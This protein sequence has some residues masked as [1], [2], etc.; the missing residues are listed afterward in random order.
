M[1]FING[2]A[3]EQ[4]TLFPP[5]LDEL[6]PDDHVCRVID[7]FVDQLEMGTLGFERAEPA[8]TG[9]PGYDPRDLLKLLLYG[10]LQQ[11]R[12]SRRLEAECRRN[13]ELMWLLGRLRPDHKSIAEFRRMH[14]DAITDTAA[15][16]VGFA[17]SE[18]LI[19]GEWVAIDGS[20]FRAVS[21]S[22]RLGERQ[23]ALRYLEQMEE[24]DA[25]DTELTINAAAVAA[26]LQKLKQDPEP[27][28][29]FMRTS[30]GNLPAYNVQAAVDAEH[31]LIVAHQVTTQAN[32]R[33]SLLPMAQAAQAAATE[34][35]QLLHVVADGG[36]SNGAQAEACEA[37]GILPHVPVQRSLNSQG[38]GAAFDR[39]LFVYNPESDTFTCPAGHSLTRKKRKARAI[40]YAAQPATCG[41][42]ALKSQCTSSTR[43]TIKRHRHE[44]A[45]QRMQQRATAEAMRLRRCRAEFPFAILKYHIFGSARFLLRGLRGAQ[46]EISLGVIA[47]NLKRM[48]KV[49]ASTRLTAALSAA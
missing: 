44:E 30:Q 6:V 9:R 2:E 49:V 47:Y 20:K 25:E 26:A 40:I 46:T 32:D 5:T 27:E 22:N 11:I 4:Q 38:G 35:G 16:L 24:A 29:R 48:C 41:S 18:G 3:R 37:R 15:E 28:A 8:D 33:R 21:S 42:C 45:L 7:A 10:Y 34:P 36:Y 19:R 14:R 23:R 39:T 1:A 17:R 13:V 31:A 12:S 43:R